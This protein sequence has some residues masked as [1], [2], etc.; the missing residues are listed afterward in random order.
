VEPPQLSG[1]EELAARLSGPVLVAGEIDDALK[2]AL[3]GP[4]VTLAPADVAA[5]RARSLGALGYERLAAGAPSEAALLRPVYL[6][7][8]AIGP[9]GR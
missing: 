4:A 3:A 1:P 8:P 2:S 7:P 9:Q 5:G 6:R